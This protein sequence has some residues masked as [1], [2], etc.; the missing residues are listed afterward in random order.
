[1]GGGG[2][3]V[4]EADPLLAETSAELI[5]EIFLVICSVLADPPLATGVHLLDEGVIFKLTRR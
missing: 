2:G 1:M 3:G 5:S 4:L